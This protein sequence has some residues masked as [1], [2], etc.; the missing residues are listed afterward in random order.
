MQGMGFLRKNTYLDLLRNGSYA[1]TVPRTPSSTDSE[2]ITKQR[3]DGQGGTN[4]FGTISV[5]DVVMVSW[6]HL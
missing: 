1:S 2:A 6:G 4:R 5:G 3:V